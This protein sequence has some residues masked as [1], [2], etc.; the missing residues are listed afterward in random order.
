MARA[1]DTSVWT[2]RQLTTQWLL[3]ADHAAPIVF[4]LCRQTLDHRG[5]AAVSYRV[6][7]Q[8]DAWT[9]EAWRA[10]LRE[11]HL[12]AERQL[13]VSL[14]IVS[15][16]L[17]P[18]GAVRECALERRRADVDG[19]FSGRP[20]RIE[21]LGPARAV[22]LYEVDAHQRL[23]ELPPE[24]EL[25]ESPQADIYMD[26]EEAALAAHVGASFLLLSRRA[27]TLAE[28]VAG[29]C[30]IFHLDRGGEVIGC[31]IGWH[32]PQ[33]YAI[34]AEFPRMNLP[35]A[36]PPEQESLV[37]RALEANRLVRHETRLDPQGLM[38]M[39]T[40]RSARNVFAVRPDS[41]RARVLPYETVCAPGSE[42]QRRWIHYAETHQGGTLLDA[43]D[44][45]LSQALVVLMADA[46]GRVWRYRIDPDGVEVAREAADDAAV[47]EHFR[48]SHCVPGAEPALAAGPGDTRPGAPPADRVR[49]LIRSLRDAADARPSAV[50]TGLRELAETCSALGLERIAAAAS[51]GAREVRH[52]RGA[53]ARMLEDLLPRL[54]RLLVE[55]QVSRPLAA[56]EPDARLA[57]PI[58]FPLASHHLAEA[59]RCL[60][61]RLPAAAVFHGMAAARAA[62]AA[63][64]VLSGRDAALGHAWTAMLRA[65]GTSDQLPN[66]ARQAL[67]EVERAWLLSGA[68]SVDKYTEREAEV[69]LAGVDAL[70]R[71]L[72]EA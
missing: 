3:S 49:G 40:D 5:D 29:F 18:S 37:C 66:A 63:A 56:D 1:D 52:G 25:A 16:T 54:E 41:G 9:P 7:G 14:L 21:F 22:R 64:E 68:D 34:V 72:A 58:R 60:E 35:L 67:A 50:G 70:V 28:S 53:T 65:A 24:P 33:P 6:H 44:D 71:R 20:A 19:P 27:P 46:T 26:G 8:D 62:L 47:A 48:A 4:A 51:E 31:G 55:E 23:I 43:Y 12:T 36:L 69:L 13:A 45:G 30:A 2:G 15:E 11:Q 17:E 59:A 39:A 32:G 61:A 38:V 10:W 42:D 57:D